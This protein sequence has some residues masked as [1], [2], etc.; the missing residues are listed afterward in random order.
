[1][2]TGLLAESDAG[3]NAT[4]EQQTHPDFAQ[5]I[6]AVSSGEPAVP[7]IAVVDDDEDIHLY[8]SELGNVGHFKVV[9][10]FYN[11]AQALARLPEDR[12]DAVIMDIRLPDMSGIECTTR[13]KTVLPELSVIILTGYPDGSTFF[14]SLV[15]GAQGF[16]VKPIVPEELLKAIGD[17][18]KGEFALTKQVV[19]FLIQLVNRV[20]HVTRET[21][22]TPREEE[23]LACLF[24]GMPDKE[25]ASALGIGTATVHTHMHRLFEKLGVHSRRDIL[26]KY[27]KLP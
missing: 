16:L 27:L 4:Q 15:A 17:V 25:I 2:Q 10:S 23:I 1:M 5:D 18:L 14:K 20:R 3:E 6:E 9:G 21:R 19:P 26:A 24:H 11:A 12:P 8:L 7:R 22:L 13:L